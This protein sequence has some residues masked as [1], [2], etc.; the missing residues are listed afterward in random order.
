[1]RSSLARLLS[2]RRIIL[3]IVSL[4]A[5]ATI[6]LLVEA[7]LAGFA[8][9]AA[10][11]DGDAIV[12]ALNAGDLQGAQAA[13]KELEK[14]ASRARSL[15]DDPLWW[16]G[17]Q[18]P[19]LGNNISDIHDS[20]TAL[21]AIASASLP[22]L[23]HLADEVAHGSLRPRHGRIDPAAIAALAPSVH[24]AAQVVDGPASTVENMSMSGLIPPLDSLMAQVKDGI[25]QAKTA[26]D[27]ASNAFE[28]LPTMLGGDGPRNYL[29]LVQNPAEI[30][31]SGGLP[32]T[33]ALIRASDGRLKMTS[34]TF[35]GNLQQ[36]T[37][38]VRLTTDESQLFGSGFG[39]S[40]N[41]ITET[42]DFPRAAQIASAIE[43][44]RGVKVSAVFAVDPVALSLVL[45]GTGPV[46]LKPDR[47]SVV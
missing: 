3:A 17:S 13:A 32:G 34:T 2:R 7:V 15:T 31:S 37:T 18:I 30:R 12:T 4:F 5:V 16:M 41:D 44:R 39:T 19:W 47:K 9:N 43:K 42:P 35:L 27:A 23:L 33:W 1:M 36:Q 46:T 11:N 40:P 10:K 8:M 22:T 21:S 29:L 6:A 45:G 20:A 28:V 24:Q 38:P 25:T 26:I 14:D